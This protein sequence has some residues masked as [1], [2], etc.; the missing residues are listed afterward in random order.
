MAETCLNCKS[1][2]FNQQESLVPAPLCVDHC[3]T[4][5]ECGVNTVF[6]KCVTTDISLS[7]LGTTSGDSLD[8]VLTAVNNLCAATQGVA[9]AKYYDLSI[10]F[11]FFAHTSGGRQSPKYSSVNSCTVKLVGNIKFTPT[12]EYVCGNVVINSVAL[13]NPPNQVRTYSVVV[14]MT[15]TTGGVSPRSLTDC[16]FTAGQIIIDTAGFIYLNIIIPYKAGATTY[17]FSLDGIYYETGVL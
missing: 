17:K 12:A 8:V 15:G 5:I 11:P 16:E 4:D 1:S 14:K 7:C 10:G 6:S 3:P 9:C 13:P 2:I